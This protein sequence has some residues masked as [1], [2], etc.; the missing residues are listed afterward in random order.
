M[1]T[2]I[3]KCQHDPLHTYLT[4]ATCAEITKRELEEA[5]FHLS[6]FTDRTIAA[7]TTVGDLRKMLRNVHREVTYVLCHEDPSIGAKAK[8][9]AIIEHITAVMED[10]K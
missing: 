10:T 1:I 7:E 9:Y 4:C 3:W 6:E 2:Q 8:L 5:R